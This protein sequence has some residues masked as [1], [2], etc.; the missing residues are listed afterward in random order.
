MFLAF[1]I[2][3]FTCLEEENGDEIQAS[4]QPG[5]LFLFSV[6]LIIYLSMCCDRHDYKSRCIYAAMD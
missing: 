2:V 4:I 3:Q 1:S 5:K 6:I